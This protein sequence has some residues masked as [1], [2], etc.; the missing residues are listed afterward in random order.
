MSRRPRS[1]KIRIAYISADFRDHPVSLLTAGLFESHDRSKFEII[2]LA[3]GGEAH[4]P[5][6][7]R[8]EGAFD[9]FIDVSA[10]S[11]A[12][13]ASLARE[14][15]VDIAV[16]LTGFTGANRTKIFALRAAPIQLSYIGYLGTMG[17]PYMD[18]LLADA[19][20][21]PMRSGRTTWSGSSACRA[22]R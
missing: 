3:Y 16:D 21:I 15:G 14:L 17:A 19:T 10:M 6:R 18:Y 8:L 2:A 5:V 4:D 20:V 12:E 22:I 1:D 11:D 7:T 13:T 9:R